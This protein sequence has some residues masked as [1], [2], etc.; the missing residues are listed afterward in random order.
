MKFDPQK[1][2]RQS[3]RLRGHD[4]T[5]AGLYFITICTYQRACLFGEI[6]NGRMRLNEYGR[7]VQTEWLRT[8]DVRP[9]VE[10][11]AFVIMPNHIHGIIVLTGTAGATRRVAPTHRIVPQPDISPGHAPTKHPNGPTSGSIGAI[12]GQF[13]SITTKQINASRNAPGAPVWQRNYHERIIRDQESL[14]RVRRYI[15]A[16]PH[17]WAEDMEYSRSL[18]NQ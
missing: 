16:N 1:H 14:H 7:V 3:I 17:R 12:I 10:M 8:V 13:K 15:E 11:D 5:Q 2:H 9:H 6:V 4:Y 18:D